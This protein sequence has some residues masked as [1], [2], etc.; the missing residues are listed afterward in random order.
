M[1]DQRLREIWIALLLALATV[2]PASTD[3]PRAGFKLDQ[4]ATVFISPIK[5]RVEQYYKEER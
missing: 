1:F 4:E 5:V 2:A 3:G